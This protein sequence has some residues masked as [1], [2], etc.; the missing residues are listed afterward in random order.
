MLQAFV[1][2][3]LGGVAG[4]ETPESPDSSYNNWPLGTDDFSKEPP[5]VPPQLHLSL[6]NTPATVDCPRR[7]PPHVVLN[8]LYIQKGKSGQPVVALG[9]SHRFLSKYVTVMLYKSL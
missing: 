2:D 6:L 7:P 4:F 8:H 5:L 3:D 9:K 1:A